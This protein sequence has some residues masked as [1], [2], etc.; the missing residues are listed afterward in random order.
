MAAI[1]AMEVAADAGFQ[2]RVKHFM[3]KAA[4]AVYAETTSGDKPAR[5]AYA[6][7]VL[8]GSASVYEY[9]VAVVTN[10]TVA[11]GGLGTSDGDLEFTVNS[12]WNAFSGVET[13]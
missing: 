8:D 4:A 9:A 5:V 3:Q 11:A 12:F 2:L 1:E 7:K 10:A 6:A 13:N